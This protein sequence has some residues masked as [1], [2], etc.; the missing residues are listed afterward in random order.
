VVN[1]ALPVN[2]LL[3]LIALAKA[4]PGQLNYGT[5]GS[6]TSTH[7]ASEMFNMLAGVKIQHI[8]YKGGDRRSPT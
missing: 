5:P 4:K 8:P 1:P 7:L 6:G 2:N 3:E